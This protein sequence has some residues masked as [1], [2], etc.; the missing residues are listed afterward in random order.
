[1]CI[2]ITSLLIIVHVLPATSCSLGFNVFVLACMRGVDRDVDGGEGSGLLVAISSGAGG[3]SGRRSLSGAFVVVVDAA[4][5]STLLLLLLLLLSLGTVS[6]LTPPPSS[7]LLSM[8][9]VSSSC[10]FTTAAVVVA[11]KE[12]SLLAV[13]GG[14]GGGSAVFAG[15]KQWS[16]CMSKLVVDA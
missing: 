9:L 12:D 8:I 5:N 15:I 7:F 1:M 14:D 3:L 16:I 4:F 13:C 6:S 2:S 11:G 10:T